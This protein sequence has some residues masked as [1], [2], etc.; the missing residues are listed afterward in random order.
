MMRDMPGHLPYTTLADLA[1]GR[2]AVDAQIQAH[3]ASCTECAAELAWIERVIRLMRNSRVFPSS[4]EA[5]DRAK[6]LF[7]RRMGAVAEGPPQRILAA[8]R[9]DSARGA[10]AFGVR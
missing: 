4:P 10:P 9:F 1:E 7:L 5:V 2:R 3:L 8:L 6:R